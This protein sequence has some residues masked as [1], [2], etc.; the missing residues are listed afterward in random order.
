MDDLFTEI[1]I[2]REPRFRDTL[3]RSFCI[4]LTIALAA[5]GLFLHP[6][7]LIGMAVLLVVM[8][9]LLPRLQVEFEYLY[10][11][12]E[13]D[14]DYIFAKKK[15]KRAA[16]YTLS[17][18]EIF[19]PAGSD[20]LAPYKKK[21]A[22]KLRDFSSGDPEKKAGVYAFVI[23]NNGDRE[24]VLIEPNST[25]LKDIRSRNASRVFLD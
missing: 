18:M 23:T 22:V 10:V 24:M 17:Q 9:F 3:L 14:V 12:G 5:A 13:L 21:D 7:F 19:A 8:Y 16:S 11:S 2:S 4:A 25:M 1:I 6:Y 20:R 15:R